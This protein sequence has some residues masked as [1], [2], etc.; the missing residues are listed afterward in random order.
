[1]ATLY[2]ASIDYAVNANLAL[3]GY[4]AWARGKGVPASIYPEG[5]NARFA[6]LEATIRF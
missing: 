3:G 6:F 2:D 4:I 5:N 1:L